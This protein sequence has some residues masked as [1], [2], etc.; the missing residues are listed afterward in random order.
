MNRDVVLVLLVG[1]VYVV[2]MLA[3]RRFRVHQIKRWWTEGHEALAAGRAEEA[4]PVFRKCLR[5]WPAAPNFHEA[6]GTAL[7]QT[8]RLEEAEQELRMAVD[9]EPSRAQSH[10][11]MSL[12]YAFAAPGRDR[13]ALEAFARVQALD[14]VL[15]REVLAKSHIAARLEDAARRSG[16]TLTD[17]AG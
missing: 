12:F 13:D 14:P 7:S 11:N 4:V 17:P 8:G 5:V 2:V 16:M 15:A 10:L 9:L 1:G 6:L 3:W